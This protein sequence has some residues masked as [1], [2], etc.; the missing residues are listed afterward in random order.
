MNYKLLHVVECVAT[1]NSTSVLQFIAYTEQMQLAKALRKAG[2][3]R[4][5][6]SS[7]SRLCLSVQMVIF[8][9]SMH[10][11]GVSTT[12]TLRPFPR[13]RLWGTHFC[14]PCEYLVSETTVKPFSV[15]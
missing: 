11:I 6:S 2:L 9:L 7:Y 15:D 8:S 1:P 12:T 14:R 10:L 4:W 13:E 5:I 3:D